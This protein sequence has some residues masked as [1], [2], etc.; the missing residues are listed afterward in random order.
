MTLSECFATSAI[1]FRDEW[2]PVGAEDDE[3]S[4]FYNN[5]KQ[6]LIKTYL[7]VRQVGGILR[8]SAIKTVRVTLRRDLFY[9]KP[10]S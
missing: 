7:K 1:T 9:S 6:L 2:S 3:E 4:A 5:D 10:A 8:D